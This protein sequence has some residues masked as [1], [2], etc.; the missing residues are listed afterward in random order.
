MNSISKRRRLKPSEPYGSRRGEAAVASPPPAAR[1]LPSVCK[2][3][4]AH[5]GG[6][7]PT[8][9]S[10]PPQNLRNCG[11]G[12]G[13]AAALAGPPR[14]ARRL[15]PA[16]PDPPAT[17]GSPAFI[18]RKGKGPDKVRESDKL[19]FRGVVF[20]VPSFSFC[21][22]A[23]PRAASLPSASHR[24]TQLPEPEQNGNNHETQP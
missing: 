14:A 24:Q 6:L 21:V 18:V 13:G 1:H 10:H 19:C 4:P 17:A 8:R 22:T 15:L 11:A 16:L 2:Y 20:W 3:R 12:A 7:A 5:I 23:S 9:R